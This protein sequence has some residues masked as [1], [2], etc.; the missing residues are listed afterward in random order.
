M[1]RYFFSFV[2]CL[3]AFTVWSDVNPQI[4]VLS[5]N[6]HIGIGMDKK[7]DLDRI[8]RIICSVTPDIVALQEVDVKTERSSGVDQAS[9]IERLTKM[10]VKFNQTIPLGS[11]QYGIARLISDSFSTV[12]GRSQHL[13]ASPGWEKRVICEDVVFSDKH[14][15]A[16]PEFRFYYTHLDYHKDDVDRFAAAQLINQ[17]ACEK[18]LQIKWQEKNLLIDTDTPSILA[19]DLNATPDSRVMDEFRKHWSIADGESMN[20]FPA[21]S[22]DRKIDY[23]LFRPAHRWRVLETRV[24]DEPAASDHRPLLV[25]LELLPE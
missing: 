15:A 4:R 8:A 14:D 23:V 10:T 12:V 16:K 11:G 18:P 5:Y 24:L 22:P 2:I 7:V 20:T 3:L 6:I 17:I 25:V 1:K 19:G 21:D 9:V 13:P